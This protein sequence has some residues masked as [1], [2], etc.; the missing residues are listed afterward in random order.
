M[1]RT[2]RNANLGQRCRTTCADAG[3]LILL[4][5]PR[6]HRLSGGL[7]LQYIDTRPNAHTSDAWYENG[8]YTD[9]SVLRNGCS[10][11]S[12]RLDYICAGLEHVGVPG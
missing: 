1:R 8:K 10:R 12:S 11:C 7:T 3:R 6:Q 2:N 4:R 5:N 9:P